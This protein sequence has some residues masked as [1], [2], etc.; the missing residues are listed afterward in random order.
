MHGLIGSPSGSQDMVPWTEADNTGLRR[1]STVMLD[2]SFAG[3]LRRDD[4]GHVLR[5]NEWS[6]IREREHVS[7]PPRKLNDNPRH[8]D[9]WR[10]SQIGQIRV[11]RATLTPSDPN[12]PSQ[13][14]LNAEHDVD[15]DSANTL[16]GPTTIVHRHSRALAFSIYR[17]YS[18]RNYRSG[19]ARNSMATVNTRTANSRETRTP[20]MSTHVTILLSTKRVQ[21][22]LTVMKSTTRLARRDTRRESNFSHPRRAPQDSTRSASSLQQEPPTPR[23]I[24]DW[25]GLEELDS[26]T[27]NIRGTTPSDIPGSSLDLLGIKTFA[28]SASTSQSVSSTTHH[29]SPLESSSISERQLSLHD[30]A[31]EDSDNK[32]VNPVSGASHP[33]AFA[34][35]GKRMIEAKRRSHWIQRFIGPPGGSTPRTVASDLDPTN[36]PWMALVPRSMKK[37]RSFDNLRL[38]RSEVGAGVGSKGKGK[39]KDRDMLSQVPDDSL[40]MLLPLWPHET[41][42]AS[43]V[44]EQG[45]Q[46]PRVQEQN[47]YLLVYYVPFDE[48]GEDNPAKKPSRS[49]LQKREQERQIDIRHGF[50][51][52]GQLVTHSDL[53]GSGIRLP[54]RGLSVTGPLAEAELAIPPASLRDMYPDSFVIGACMDGSGTTI[55]F[56]PE[57]LEKLGLCV[58]RTEPVRLDIDPAEPVLE[59]PLTAIGRAAVEVAWLGCMALMTFDGPQSQG[60]A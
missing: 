47:M 5:R 25:S 8:C 30:E 6:F 36:P 26:Q 55:E 57:G 45:Q 46:T 49:R 38:T 19:G 52:I 10:C 32:F 37:G 48:R 28:S 58:P 12:K 43:A 29:M 2:D 33:E 4:S 54:V 17:H 13:Q 14:R 31:E 60:P 42:A 27:S 51:V 3:G 41:D 56:F 24:V 39:G 15:P 23:H 53:N 20:V 7:L 18:P 11:E 40:Y 1:P 22:Q 35:F 9:V 16:G 50:K 34:T 21:G 44:D 59:Q